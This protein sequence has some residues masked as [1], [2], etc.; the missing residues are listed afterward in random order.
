[1]DDT[2]LRY[3]QD[4]CD[5]EF[6]ETDRLRGQDD[7]AEVHASLAIA[8]AIRVHALVIEAALQQIAHSG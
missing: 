3:W 7:S 4:R 5:V 6:K 8:A 2:L 1:M